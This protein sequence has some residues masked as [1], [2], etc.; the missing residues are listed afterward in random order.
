M[1]QGCRSGDGT[2][3]YGF[4]AAGLEVERL[5]WSRTPFYLDRGLIPWTWLG[6]NWGPGPGP[7]KSRI[8][9]EPVHQW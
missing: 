5:R 9:V 6:L 4:G 3:P 2:R 1:L 7:S 8:K